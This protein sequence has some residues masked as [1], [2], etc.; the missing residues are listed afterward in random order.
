MTLFHPA[1]EQFQ[2]ENVLTALGNPTRL[3]VVR[4]LAADCEQGH[5][6]GALMTNVAKSTLTHHWRVL[7]EAGVI[8]Q[9]PVGRE[10]LIK[11]RRH[12]MD[13]RFPGLLDAVLAAAQPAQTADDGASA[14]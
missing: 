1:P 9:E 5:P 3:E 2:V 8:R 14:V 12:E 7:R 4:K 10:I 13:S 6:C 11:L